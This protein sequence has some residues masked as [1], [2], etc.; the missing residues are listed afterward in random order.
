MRRARRAGM[1][2]RAAL[3][4]AALLAGCSAGTAPSASV[5]VVLDVA[6]DVNPDASGRPSPIVVRVYQ[7]ADTEAFDRATFFDLYDRD[8]QVLGASLLARSEITL[9]PDTEKVVGQPLDPKTRVV[10]IVAAYRDIDHA[11]WRREFRVSGPGSH[12][13]AVDLERS[14][15]RPDPDASEKAESPP[16]ISSNDEGMEPWNGIAG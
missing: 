13:I 11:Q 9:L 15:I 6:D 16:T 1:A 4:L 2:A 12:G 10:A 14:S 8:R 5:Q 7:L 3:M